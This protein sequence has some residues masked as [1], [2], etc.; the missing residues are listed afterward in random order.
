MFNKGVTNFKY[1]SNITG[2]DILNAFKSMA[3]INK[4]QL[5]R[6][7]KRANTGINKYNRFKGNDFKIKTKDY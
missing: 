2:V 1:T 4:K 3:G 6:N 5:N 7:F